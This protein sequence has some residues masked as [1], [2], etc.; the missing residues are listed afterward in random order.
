MIRP[1]CTTAP[2]CR[3]R[4]TSPRPPRTT[5][6]RWNATSSPSRPMKRTGSSPNSVPGRPGGPRPPPGPSCGRRA[7]RH[8]RVRRLRRRLRDHPTAQGRTGSHHRR[9]RPAGCPGP[10][11]RRLRPVP[12]PGRPG[13]ETGPV[14]RD[15]ERPVRNTASRRRRGGHDA[16]AA[17]DTRPPHSPRREFDP[18][19]H[20]GR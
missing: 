10:G 20:V 13:G 19:R 7:G 18:R 1:S 5:S 14:T 8:T 16:C 12:P 15:R 4:S 17:H 11:W 2:G 3:P 6:P 9:R